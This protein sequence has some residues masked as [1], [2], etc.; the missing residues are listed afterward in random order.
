MKKWSFVVLWLFLCFSVVEVQAKTVEKAKVEPEINVSDEAFNED[1]NK[2][3]E[4]LQR[5]IQFGK[6]HL[7][8]YGELHYNGLMGAGANQIDFHRMVL[9]FGYDFTDRILFRTEVDFEHAF[10]EPE[11]EFAQVDFLVRD[12]IN[13]RVGSILAPVGVINQH[14]EPP[15]FFS[16][17]RPEVYRLIIPTTWQEGGGGIFGKLPRGF[18]YEL[19]VLSMPRAVG[20]D[21]GG[22]TG[23]S[24]LRNG[25]GHVGSQ[26]ARDFGVYGRLQYKGLPGLR[27]GTSFVFGNTGQGNATVDGGTLAM[28]EGDAKYIFQGI[29]L[30]AMVAFNSL[31]DAGNINTARV[32]ADATFTNFVGSQMLGWYFEGAYHIFHHVLPSAKHDVVVFGR[33]E[34]I[35]TQRSMPTG[36]AKNNANDRQLVTAGIS[37]LPIP[38]VALK[39]DY[40][41]NWNAANAGVDQFNLGLGFYY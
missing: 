20:G 21:D 40:T 23:S 7:F 9:G 38:Q 3:H 33:Y 28:I 10:K 22:F 4:G 13:F 18:D 16:V 26:L 27:A 11:L 39:A 41:W 36:F 14:H 32:A 1:L 30:E 5:N 15:L 24:G 12:W 2:D 35:D 19:Y 25:R 8:G 34:N 31:S 6:F 29:E 37:Y 17:E